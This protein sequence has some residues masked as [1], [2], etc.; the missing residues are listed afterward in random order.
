MRVVA[1]STEHS[2]CVLNDKYQLSRRHFFT[3]AGNSLILVWAVRFKNNNSSGSSRAVHRDELHQCLP[4]RLE[5]VMVGDEFDLRDAPFVSFLSVAPLWSLLS[6]EYLCDCPLD[7]NESS[8][9]Q[10]HRDHAGKLHKGTEANSVPALRLIQGPKLKLCLE[11]LEASPREPPQRKV[12]QV[13][14]PVS[15]ETPALI[16]RLR[17]FQTATNQIKPGCGLFRH[18]DL[19]VCH[20]LL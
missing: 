3:D 14:P 2:T 16:T 13:R 4:G 12:S 17:A 1:L 20:F 15:V 8:G 9:V 11:L 7:A 18:L 10:G 5:S 6:N 19:L